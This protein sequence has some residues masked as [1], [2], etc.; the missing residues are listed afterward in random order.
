MEKL[1]EFPGG[2]LNRRFNNSPGVSIPSL[3]LTNGMA[4]ARE[5]GHYSM[6]LILRSAAGL[7]LLF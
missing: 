6:Q 4:G 3:C 7:L 1:G 2:D 5:G